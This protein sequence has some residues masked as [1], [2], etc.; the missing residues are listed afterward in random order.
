MFTNKENTE[1][2]LCCALVFFDWK[3]LETVGNLR[4]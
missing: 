4:I 1:L 3:R 2:V